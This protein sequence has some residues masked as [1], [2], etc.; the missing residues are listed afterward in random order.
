MN[1]GEAALH[2]GLLGADAQM[3]FDRYQTQQPGSPVPANSPPSSTRVQLI[4]AMGPPLDS[5]AP[6]RNDSWTLFNPW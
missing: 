5:G 1:A 4:A 6:C 2:A 3:L